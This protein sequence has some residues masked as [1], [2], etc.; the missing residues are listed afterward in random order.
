MRKLIGA[1]IIASI[2]ISIVAYSIQIPGIIAGIITVVWLVMFAFAVREIDS[3]VADA[4]VL[5][6]R[7]IT[8]VA[9][10]IA[11]TVGWLALVSVV[12]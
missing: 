6:S 11:I 8:L 10:I 3:I 12:Q 4:E 7:K 9:G 2:V 1:S 5:L